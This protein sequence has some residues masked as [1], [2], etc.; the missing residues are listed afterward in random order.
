MLH[1][2][3]FQGCVLIPLLQNLVTRAVPTLSQPQGCPRVHWERRGGIIASF[4][5]LSPAGWVASGSHFSPPYSHS[6]AYCLWGTNMRP[7]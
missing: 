2:L 4:S 1:L 6:L 7:E 3:G 5:C